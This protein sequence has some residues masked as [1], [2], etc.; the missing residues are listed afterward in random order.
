MEGEF[1]STQNT[2]AGW[3][4][5]RKEWPDLFLAVWGGDP[6]DKILSGLVLDGTIVRHCLCLAFPLPSRLRHCL[7]LC[8]YPLTLPLRS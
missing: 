2:A 5:A 3:R 4:A 6:R 7:C 1:N 8:A